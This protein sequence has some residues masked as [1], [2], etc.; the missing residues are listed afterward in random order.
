MYLLR[1][2]DSSSNLVDLVSQNK[3]IHHYIGLYEVLNHPQSL[4]KFRPGHL[5][6]TTD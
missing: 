5:I 4:N 6:K 1:I 2:S 3:L